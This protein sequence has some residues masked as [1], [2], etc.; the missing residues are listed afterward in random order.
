VIIWDD[1]K[2]RVLFTLPA[3]TTVRGV[4][5]SRTHIVIVLQTSVK[6]Y[7]FEVPPQPWGE[8]QT[9]ENP[10][11]ICC[12][13]TKHL[14]IPAITSG[15]VRL[16]ELATKNVSLVPAHTS[17]LRALDISRDGQILATASETVSILLA[18]E[19]RF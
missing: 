4:R 12:L 2:Q 8:Y 5:I 13:G 18:L 3:L 15:Q 11:G 1:S 16:I 9:V 10:Y 6:V 7:K 14:A 19:G 17:P